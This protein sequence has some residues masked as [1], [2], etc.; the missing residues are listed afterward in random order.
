MNLAS[1]PRIQTPL[2]SHSATKQPRRCQCW[3]E[4]QGFKVGDE[5]GFFLQPM[6]VLTAKTVNSTPCDARH[7]AQ[8]MVVTASLRSISLCTTGTRLFFQKTSPQSKQRPFFCAGV[9]GYHGIADLGL[10]SGA[11]VAIISVGGLGHLGAQ[12]AFSWG[13][14]Y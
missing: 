4:C 9:T 7:T 14:A 2:P 5:V 13:K 8:G 1:S 3:S 6:S 12:T 11:W 10:P